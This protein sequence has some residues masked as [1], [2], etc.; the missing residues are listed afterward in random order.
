[1]PPE[2]ELPWLLR[3]FF[4]WLEKQPVL[5]GLIL[6]MLI[7]VFVGVFL[8]IAKKTLSSTISWRGMS[9]KAIM[10]LI[11]GMAAVLQP[12]LPTIPLLN[13]VAGFYS[14]TEALSIVENAAAAGVPLPH[15][16][17]DTLAKLKDSQRLMR[18]QKSIPSPPPPDDPPKPTA[19]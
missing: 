4:V 17:V 2:I 3:A 8:S 9:K 6:L 7:D 1:M 16:L 12:F 15:G 18:E 19:T 13:L 5:G 11:L 10:L 14:M